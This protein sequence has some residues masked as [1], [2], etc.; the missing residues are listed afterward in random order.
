MIDCSTATVLPDK[1]VSSARETMIK[2]CIGIISSAEGGKRGRKGKS[3]KE[4][5]GARRRRRKLDVGLKLIN[6]ECKGAR[7]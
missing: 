4:T 6:G 7:D 5:N 2:D 3:K 1:M